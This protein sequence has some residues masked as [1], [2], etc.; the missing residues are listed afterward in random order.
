[1]KSLQENIKKIFKNSLVKKG[2]A[3]TFFSTINNG[4]NFFLI[5]ILS[6]YLSKEDF[7]ILNLFNVLFLIISV[8]ISLGTQSYFGIAFFKRKRDCLIRSLNSIVVISSVVFLFLGIIIFAFP[9]TLENILGFSTKYQFYALILCLLQL[10]YTTNLEVYRLEE[11]PL[12]YGVLSSIWAIVN[13]LFTIVFCIFLH[14]GWTGRIDAQLLSALIIF[15]INIIILYRKEYLKFKRPHKRHYIETLK[16]GLPLVPHNST[17][18]LRQ[19]F[20]R[21]IINFF[22]GAIVVGSYSFAYTL[23][24]IILMIGTAFNAT[25]SVYIFKRL[26]DPD[27]SDRSVLS[28]QIYLMTLLFGVITI[29]GGVVSYCLITFFIPKYIDAIPYLLPLFLAAFFQCVYYLFV[30]YLLYYNKTKTLMYITFSI[31]IFHFLLSL[32]LTKYSILCTAYISL[33]SNFIICILVIFHAN[34]TFRL[35]NIVNKYKIRN[36]E[37]L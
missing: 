29:F 37:L 11:K 6:I 25:N 31:S 9:Q 22:H 14:K 20:D 34:K 30:N 5:L 18:W 3:F 32:L 16:F 12:C 36:Y 33:L 4:L 35:F 27:I 13:F 26:S 28:K 19:G 7:G 10:F 15:L 1:L 24:G 21:Y 2:I 8:L 23:S 17:V